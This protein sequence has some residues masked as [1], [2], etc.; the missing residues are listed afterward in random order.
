MKIRTDWLS[1]ARKHEIDI[2]RIND[3]CEISELFRNYSIERYVYRIKYKGLVIKFGMSSPKAR[4]A[5]NGDRLYRQIGHISS[6]GDQRLTGSNGAD[7]RIA[8]E[9]FE[10]LYGYKLDHRFM[11]AT[12]W[13]LTKFPFETVEPDKEVNA[14]ENFLIEE[15]I[16]IV[17]E[18]PIGN[19]NDESIVKRRAAVPLSLMKSLFFEEDDPKRGDNTTF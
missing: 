3:P 17:G 10:K 16:R 19:I 8:E 6:W 15:Y 12:V 14:I 5:R 2:S 7:F 1:F 18:K 4:S 11:T 9:D 13:D